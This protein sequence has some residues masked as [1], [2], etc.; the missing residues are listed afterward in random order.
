[1]AFETID[2][3]IAKISPY[4]REELKRKEKNKYDM[5]Q[6]RE[7]KMVYDTVSDSLEPV[8]F[9]ILDLMEDMGFTVEKLVDNFSSSPGSGHFG[10][11]GGRT[12]IMQQQGTKILGDI[13]NVMRSVL[14]LVYDLKEFKIRL[15]AYDDLKSNEK[16]EAALM[17]LKQVWMDKVDIN[18]GNSS[19]KAMALGQGGFVTLIDA[20]LIAKDEKDVDKI[21]LNDRV[22]RIL[23]TRVQ[24]FNLWLKQSEIELRK[25]YEMER[26]YLK[27]QVN[28]LKIYSRWAKPYLKAAQQLEQKEQGRNPDFVKTFDTVIL[29]MTLLGKSEV[30]LPVELSQLKA[31]KYYKCVLVD[32]YFRGI[33]RKIAQ[34]SHY[35]FGGR[36]EITFKAY[37]L[38]ED[39]LAK[40]NEEMEKS[41]LSDAFSLIEGAT[42]ES[43]EVLQ[44]EIDSFL[45]EGEEKSKETSS[46]DVNP[47][48]ALFGYYEKKSSEGKKADE[49]KKIVKIKKESFVER[50]HL[51]IIGVEKSNEDAFNFF[52][53]FK[54]AHDMA[55]YT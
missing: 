29:E 25:R 48:L 44:E 10:E 26:A 22:K 3:L 16:K 36:A 9:W 45:K 41:D 27:S 18:K 24:E 50:E 33:P 15:G 40:L 4:Y 53:Y 52:D 13:N 23:Q 20:F 30:S 19:I 43:I 6:Q 42:T 34:Q 28:S 17:S 8:Y 32:F 51:R 11:F 31:R 2:Q 7:H 21:D 35:S 49:V 39:E 54:K 38:N 55:S 1:M 14:N 37:S 12:T 46:N 5:L 47:F